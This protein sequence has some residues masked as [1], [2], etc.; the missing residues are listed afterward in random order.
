MNEE[1]GYFYDDIPATSIPYWDKRCGE[2][3]TDITKMDEIFNLFLSKLETYQP[4]QYI[5]ENLSIEKCEQKL[6]DLIKS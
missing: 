2:F 4:R 5:L 3:F 1:Y 6:I